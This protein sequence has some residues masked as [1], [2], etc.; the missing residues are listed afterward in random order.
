MLELLL[1]QL[2]IKIDIVEKKI[3]YSSVI[4]ASI[5]SILQLEA[6]IYVNSFLYFYLKLYF[7]SLSE[8][9]IIFVCILIHELQPS[10]LQFLVFKVIHSF[11]YLYCF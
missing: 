1:K 4:L 8:N 5:F 9:F 11:F 3:S 6:K 2:C 7:D 10:M